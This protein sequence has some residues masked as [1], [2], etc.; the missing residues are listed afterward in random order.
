MKFSS[1]IQSLGNTRGSLKV[2]ISNQ[3]IHLLS[4]Q[5][6]SSPIKAI[7]ELVVNAYDADATVCRIGFIDQNSPEDSAI[8]IFDD[9]SGMD[10]AGLEHLWFVGASPKKIDERTRKHN[11]R[12]IGKFGIGKLATY[13]VANKITYLT[14]HENGLFHV[15]C[16]FRK[17]ES[18]TTGGAEKAVSLDVM[19]VSDVDEL[20]S[21]DELAGVINTLCMSSND[22]TN[23]T[24]KSWTVC[25]L[26]SLKE[27]SVNIK[28]GRL[29]WVIKT[30]MPLKVDFEIVVDGEKI[31]RT[32]ADFEPIIEFPLVEIADERLK[33]LNQKLTAEQSWKVS[34]NRLISSL[35]PNGVT[36]EV[37]ITQRSLVAGKSADIGRSHGFFVY[38]RERL[39]NQEDELFGLH[40]LSHR[41]F[42]FFR[43]DV[44]ADDLH[45][46]V[47]APREGIG[48]GERQT[49]ISE[50]LLALFNEARQRQ[51]E[52]ESNLEEQE[53]RKKEHERNFVSPRL[54]DQPIAD[55]LAI[56]ETDDVG[57][58][59]DEG[60]FFLRDIDPSSRNQVVE[61]LYNREK[62]N[63]RF[64]YSQLGKTERMVKLD[65]QRETFMLNE[66]H[67]VVLAHSDDPR[68]RNL[69]E[70][71]VASEVMLEVYLREAG[72]NPF[73][74]GE[75]LERRDFLLRSFAQDSV[76]SLE[77]LAQSLTD[78]HD[79]QYNLEIAVVAA[80]RALGFNTKH[81]SGA[82]QPDGLARFNDY[83]GGE[84]KITLEAK[85][86]KRTPE[87][88]A[89]DFSG[90]SEHIQRSKADGCLLVAPKYPGEVK[91]SQDPDQ[92]SDTAAESRAK[93]TKV[94]CWTIKDLVKIVRATESHQITAAQVLDIVLNKFTPHD[95]AAAVEELL[96][97]D[98]MK[99]YYQEILRT[100]RRLNAPGVLHKSI[101][102]V[103]HISAILSVDGQLSSVTDAKVRRA[104][105]NMSNASKGM[106]RIS[107]DR[108]IFSGDIDEF[109]RRVTSLTGDTV[110]PR[111][112][113]NF[114]N[115]ESDS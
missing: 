25:V 50:L 32:K 113:G 85:S 67:E 64:T 35:F 13:A 12:V 11:R 70:D 52:H 28:P 102:R 58:D 36:G 107:G 57:T 33:T 111:K 66:D 99:K 2:R 65:P 76:Y 89:L 114:R 59:A 104:L 74:I 5:M 62:R 79:D 105:V 37:L 19:E 21:N 91:K 94:S 100:L 9:G 29:K 7:E 4:E 81:V 103:Q 46:D 101:R 45:A 24:Y 92:D 112:L 60:W 18:S 68:A 44:F 20:R 73:V 71:L 47:T 41:T 48:Q 53:K 87:L 82:G 23:G 80:S 56:L 69:L 78:A 14:S 3:L 98:D 16:D 84:K 42:N 88:S 6:Y 26:E 39:V 110:S 22:L 54:V 15:S 38:V 96:Q 49:A 51:L 109:A 115:N 77:S 83:G 72:I 34:S 1:S 10:Y 8:V 40:A 90:L 86:S 43:A 97:T 106:V 93:A 75:V 55:T 61:H 63:Y 30:A 31:E 27:K 95:V 108:I 17:F